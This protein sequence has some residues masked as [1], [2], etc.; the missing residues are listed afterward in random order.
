M[1]RLNLP[2][3]IRD[4]A[5]NANASTLA[6]LRAMHRAAREHYPSHRPGLPTNGQQ[7][8]QDNDRRPHPT[9]Q[10]LNALAQVTM[11]I[12]RRRKVS[13]ELETA[14]EG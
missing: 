1:H 3:N 11:L 8:S 14:S 5:H 6:A 7:S 12:G 4:N 2:L 9:T 10:H 13:R